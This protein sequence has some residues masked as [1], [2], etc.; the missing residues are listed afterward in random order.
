[1]QGTFMNNGIQLRWLNTAGFEIIMSN[2]KHILLDPFLSGTIGNIVSHPISLD[3]IKGCD[4]L[5][6]SHIHCD[7]ANDVEQIQ[8]KFP[9]L[10]LF[11]GDLSADPLCTWQNINCAKLYRVRPG[12]VY[13]F[14]DLKI[15]VFAGRHT[16][17][18]RGYYR[19]DFEHDSTFDY[20][21]WFGNLEFQ[22][23][24]L[25][26]CDGTKIFVWGGM[27]SPDQI[28]RFA[29]LNPDIALM[30]VSPKQSFEEFAH[31]TSAMNTQVIIPHHYDFSKAMLDADPDKI[32]DMSLENQKNF[33][34]NGMFS[35]AKYMDALNKVCR[36]KKSPAFCCFIYS[37]GRGFSC[38]LFSLFH[39]FKF[40][41]GQSIDA[42]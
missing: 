37:K 42:L 30:H 15:E 5:L 4:Y 19:K 33:V 6:L 9:D 31:L 14:D 17:S 2:G 18:P 1:M 38:Y 22:N 16:E 8:K 41:S 39:R 32:K 11:V 40:S 21:G 25:T 12:E 26:C 24:L 34:V 29:G 20:S 23:Y 28:H 10:N 36:E 35:F 3:E 27:T 7:H 13:E